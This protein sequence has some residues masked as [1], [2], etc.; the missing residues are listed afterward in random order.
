LGKDPKLLKELKA[1]NQL[2][3]HLSEKAK[4]AKEAYEVMVPRLH[5]GPPKQPMTW[6]LQAAQELIVRDLLDPTT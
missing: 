5:K 2:S 3:S 1:S 6:A 4:R